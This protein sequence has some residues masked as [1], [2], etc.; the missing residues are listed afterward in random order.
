MNINI[1]DIWYVNL[2]WFL[3]NLRNIINSSCCSVSFL[4]IIKVIKV[5]YAWVKQT[6][7]SH[8]PSLCDLFDCDMNYCI[9]MLLARGMSFFFVSQQTK[10]KISS[11]MDDDDWLTALT[12]AFCAT[13]KLVMKNDPY[14]QDSKDEGKPQK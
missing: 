10:S 11:I 3:F 5:D 4:Y 13:K 7:P 2:A 9:A 8:S 14:T 12:V 6:L 1:Y